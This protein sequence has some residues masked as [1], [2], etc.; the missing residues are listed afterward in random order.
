[1]HAQE[2]LT[3]AR[4]RMQLLSAIS[5][6]LICAA[7]RTSAASPPCSVATWCRRRA[8]TPIMRRRTERRCNQQKGRGISA[9][10]SA[11]IMVDH[12]PLAPRQ[13]HERERPETGRRATRPGGGG[14]GP[15]PRGAF[16]GG[17]S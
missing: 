9:T 17:V 3:A 14:G 13:I 1:M 7:S 4:A 12:L 16:L 8:G 5:E 15:A 11:P 6:E 10:A 2:R